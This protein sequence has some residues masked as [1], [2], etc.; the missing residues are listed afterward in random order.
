MEITPS[1]INNHGFSGLC[2]RVEN[3]NISL[4][5]VFINFMMY[6]F[7]IFHIFFISKFCMLRQLQ[8]L[9]IFV[10]GRDVKLAVFS[11]SHQNSKIYIKTNM[12]IVAMLTKSIPINM[13]IASMLLDFHFVQ[14]SSINLFVDILLIFMNHERIFSW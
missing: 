10:K 7:V 3:F 2:G 14:V 9:L 4:S 13:D 1:I 12:E 11:I 6:V 8:L 5:R